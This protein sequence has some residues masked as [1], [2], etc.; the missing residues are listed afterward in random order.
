MRGMG[1]ALDQHQN[2][3]AVHLHA[4]GVLDGRGFGLMLGLL[5]HGRETEELAG[6]G[7]IDDHFL[8]VVVHGGHAHAA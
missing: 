2:V 5:Q 4:Y 1:L 3:V 7:L 8:I 6:P